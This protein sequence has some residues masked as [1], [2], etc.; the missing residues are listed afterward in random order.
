MDE[1]ALRLFEQWKAEMEADPGIPLWPKGCTPKFNGEFGQPEPSIVPFLL[2]KD[3]LPRAA[4]IV[5]PG[6]GYEFKAPHEGRPLAKWFNSIGIHAFVLDYRVAPYTIDCPL[7]DAKRA[8]RQVRHRSVEWGIDPDKIG[9]MGF[10]AGGHLTIMASEWFDSGDPASED[11]V[12]QVSSRPNAQMPCYPLV[13]YRPFARSKHAEKWL[14][15]VFGEGYG[16]P[17]VERA[18][19]EL[20]VRSDTPPAFIWGTFEDFLIKQWPPFLKALEKRKVPYAYHIFP[21]GKHGLGMAQDIPEVSQWTAVCAVWLKE[22][23]FI[24]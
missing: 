21:K 5:C 9:I 12:E 7:L 20:N 23:G 17:D 10:S 1:G 22:L 19:G 18:A 2:P 8:I 15:H 3:G 14:P 4:V 24:I 13:S 11:P 6:G 16:S